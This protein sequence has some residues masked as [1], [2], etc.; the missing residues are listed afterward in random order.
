M[1]VVS[2]Q[3]W[4]ISARNSSRIATPD[5]RSIPIRPIVRPKGPTPIPGQI[6]AE[7][8]GL[9]L[10]E[11][12]RLGFRGADATPREV[13]AGAFRVGDR[14]FSFVPSNTFRSSASVFG[15]F[16]ATDLLS[17]GSPRS[18]VFIRD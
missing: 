16:R 1:L 12:K 9:A 8:D 13:S 15:G 2:T 5:P 18:P 17:S 6:S 11:T 14:P 7:I 3:R 10:Q 4:A